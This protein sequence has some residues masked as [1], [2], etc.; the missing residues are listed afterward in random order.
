MELLADRDPEE[1]RKILD[2]VLADEM[3]MR[4]LTARCHL[5]LGKLARRS[6]KLEAAREHLTIALSMFRE[7]DMG[8]WPNQAEAELRALHEGDLE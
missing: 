6:G 2:P 8:Y 5:D 4:P 1:A 7:M 3:G